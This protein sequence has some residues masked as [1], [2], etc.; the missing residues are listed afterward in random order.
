MLDYY[1][2]NYK[3]SILY[4]LFYVIIISCNTTNLEVNMNKKLEVCPVCKYDLQ[5][6]DHPDLAYGYNSNIYCDYC[7]KNMKN[8]IFFHCTSDRL[9]HKYGF[10]LCS[11][12]LSNL[13]NN[14][15]KEDKDFACYF[16]N[17][18][19]DLN[20][21]RT[22]TIILLQKLIKNHYKKCIDCSHLF[23][24]NDYHP[25]D[26]ICLGC[27]NTIKY[28]DEAFSH[29]CML[30]NKQYY[31]C[32]KCFYSPDVLDDGKYRVL[33]LYDKLTNI[34][35][36]CSS[37]DNLIEECKFWGLAK[38]DIFLCNKCL[39]GGDFNNIINAIKKSQITSSNNLVKS[40]FQN[41]NYSE[42]NVKTS[43]FWII[44][45]ELSI[46]YNYLRQNDYYENGDNTG[47][48]KFMKFIDENDF[49]EDDLEEELD[50]DNEE[51]C[52]YYEFDENFPL[53]SGFNEN[54]KR[55]LIFS[56][57]QYIYKYKTINGYN[58][59]N[60]FSKSDIQKIQKNTSSDLLIA[61]FVNNYIK[62]KIFPLEL[63][64]LIS[65]Y[66]G[67]FLFTSIVNKIMKDNPFESYIKSF[68]QNHL[69]SDD[70]NKL[71]LVNNVDLYINS[72]RCK[73]SRMFIMVNNY[74]KYLKNCDN[75]ILNQVWNFFLKTTS[76]EINP[77]S[78]IYIGYMRSFICNTNNI[79]AHMLKAFLIYIN[80]NPNLN[81]KYY[82]YD[83]YS[84]GLSLISSNDLENE[85]ANQIE[86][87]TEKI[88]KQISCEQI[89][90]YYINK[91]NIAKSIENL[92]LSKNC[93]DYYPDT[94]FADEDIEIYSGLHKFFKAFFLDAL[95]LS[96]FKKCYEFVNK[97]EIDIQNTKELTAKGI[98]EILNNLKE[99]IENNNTFKIKQA[100]KK[101]IPYLKIY[102]I[103][104]K[105]DNLNDG[106][107]DR[108]CAM[109][110]NFNSF[111]N[112][113]YRT[114]PDLVEPVRNYLGFYSNNEEKIKNCK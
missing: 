23:Y 36:A 9:F 78:D 48:G 13:N 54:E 75:V 28:L 52:Q 62:N 105:N 85:Y 46:Y 12:C 44:D 42:S 94:F 109:E 10:D 32:E 47:K 100:R 20:I 50:D 114:R 101:A 77:N 99:G 34:S 35:K 61:G 2:K 26:E 84:G 83:E 19:Y 76:N 38:K 25:K 103:V 5:E 30:K 66:C 95:R 73:L 56:I 90:N 11:P 113:N 53:L 58:S 40:P 22:P 14:M 97:S 93:I 89:I 63:I 107:I 70:C 29:T 79:F 16:Y 31:Y 4:I 24:K 45:R 1:L 96:I 81:S 8:N 67:T 91:K 7:S 69:I 106:I 68:K 104:F 51:D 21:T 37:C 49:E 3:L 15:N 102:G 59:I 39:F 80:P 64:F 112:D 6:L 87:F 74:L 111:I 82:F 18:F 86:L 72:F 88:G 92:I 41:I 60:F 110:F 108:K 55:N 65:N 57:L 43:I 71:Y 27:D 98:I 33:K 17:N